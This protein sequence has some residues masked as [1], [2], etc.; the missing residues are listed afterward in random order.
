[1][2]RENRRMYPSRYTEF[3]G[4]A[5]WK[6]MH[7]IAFT[8]P[9]SPTPEQRRDYID[10]FRSLGPVIPCPS[11]SQHYQ[12]YLNE[13]PIDGDNTDSL[14]RWVYNL[15]DDVNKRRGKDSPSFE[16][17]QDD[18]TGWTQSKHAALNKLPAARRNRKLADP[19]LGRTP[20][21]VSSK[22]KE[23]AHASDAGGS[24]FLILIVVGVLLLLVF[25]KRRQS[26]SEKE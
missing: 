16:E 6:A 4:P 10:F 12:E 1:M 11:C 22:N 17:V 5:L 24:N 15:H 13:H 23:H 18:Y 25:Q 20:G 26:R 14:A 2:Q 7:A 8:Y 19:H 3:W 21:A 9:D